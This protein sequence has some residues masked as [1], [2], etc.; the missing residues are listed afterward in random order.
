MVF[1]NS[2]VVD[3]L[4][5][6][7]LQRLRYIKTSKSNGDLKYKFNKFLLSIFVLAFRRGVEKLRE[8]G[9]A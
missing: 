7:V 1:I 8:G 4:I 6:S 5:Y 9:E 3:Y 2:N